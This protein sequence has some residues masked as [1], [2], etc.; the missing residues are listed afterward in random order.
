[1]GLANRS[2]EGEIVD[3]VADGGA[4]TSRGGEGGRTKIFFSVSTSSWKGSV[5]LILNPVLVRSSVTERSDTQVSQT[6]GVY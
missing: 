4:E 1:M 6:L 2:G 3:C 5:A